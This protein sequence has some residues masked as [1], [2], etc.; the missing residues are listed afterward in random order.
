MRES[1]FFSILV[2]MENWEQKIVSDF[3]NYHFVHLA[4]QLFKGSFLHTIYQLTNVFQYAH[5]FFRNISEKLL[6]LYRNGIHLSYIIFAFSLKIS[7]R[8]EQVTVLKE[9][10]LLNQEYICQLVFSGL[11]SRISKLITLFQ[12]TLVMTCWF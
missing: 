4:F 12:S 11:I 9:N 1:P 5:V 8:K 10:K 6:K 3:H 7:V 2:F